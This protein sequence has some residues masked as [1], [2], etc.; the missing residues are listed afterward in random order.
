M[1]A[2]RNASAGLQAQTNTFPVSRPQQPKGVTEQRAAN[3]WGPGDLLALGGRSPRGG[4]V[5]GALPA[6][7]GLA[8]TIHDTRDAAGAQC[9]TSPSRTAHGGASHLTSLPHQAGGRATVPGRPVPCQGLQR[10][11][12]PPGAHGA[13]RRAAG[14]CPGGTPR[15]SREPPRGPA[16]RPGAGR[17]AEA[18][19]PL[20]GGR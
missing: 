3:G 12:S 15:P 8:A 9:Q 2:Q 13:S 18:A 16:R 4:A 17:A 1:C 5:R 6:C 10:D 14:R 20:G 11:A 7:P 19:P